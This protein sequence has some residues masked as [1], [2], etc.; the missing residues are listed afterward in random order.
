MSNNQVNTSLLQL[1]KQ[2]AM[3]VYNSSKPATVQVGRVTKVKPLTIKVG[4]KLELD[5]D[6]LLVP[7]NIKKDLVKGVNVALVRQQGGQQFLVVGVLEN[8]SE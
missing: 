7:K 6:F 3:D 2:I 5:S 4:Q 8:D 1:I